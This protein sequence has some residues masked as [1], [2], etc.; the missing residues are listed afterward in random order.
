MDN[1][2]FEKDY[3]DEQVKEEKD[4]LRQSD[5]YLHIL[6]KLKILLLEYIKK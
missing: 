2:F 3:F 1:N 4:K 5:Y 6:Q